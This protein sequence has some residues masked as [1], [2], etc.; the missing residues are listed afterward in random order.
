MSTRDGN[1]LYDKFLPWLPHEA[2][3][4]ISANLDGVLDLVNDHIAW[5]H[6]H[7][8]NFSVK[9]AYNNIK[10][11]PQIQNKLK[12]RNLWC[13]NG[14][15]QAKYFLSLAVKEGLKTKCFLWERGL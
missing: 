2:I 8:G 14:P 5:K 12:W 3:D 10:D 9:I 11:F 4:E 15:I 6:S 13:W 1:W 7:D